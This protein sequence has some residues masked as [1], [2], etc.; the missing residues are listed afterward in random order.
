MLTAEDVQ[1]VRFS[2]TKF[3]EGYDQDDVDDMLDRVVAT[4]RRDPSRRAV[5]AD[6]VYRTKFSSTRFRE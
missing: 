1:R 6:E 2:P 5:T 3:R 4:L